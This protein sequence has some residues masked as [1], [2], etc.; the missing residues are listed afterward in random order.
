MLG[1][2]GDCGILC[3]VSLVLCFLW[4]PLLQDVFGDFMLGFFFA[5][6]RDTQR[7]VW[8]ALLQDVFGGQAGV[9]RRW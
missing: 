1:E 8:F 9:R 5:F 3:L 7:I 4:C 2:E 6:C